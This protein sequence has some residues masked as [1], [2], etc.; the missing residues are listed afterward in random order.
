[1]S[2]ILLIRLSDEK[3]QKKKIEQNNI[4]FSLNEEEKTADIVGIN[5]KIIDLIIPKSIKYESK[6]Y[7]ITSILNG[8]F[9]GS[10]IKSLNFTPDSR[11][12]TIETDAFCRTSI[13]SLTI[14]SQVAELKE[15][16]CN[17]TSKLTNINV[18]PNN[19]YFKTYENHLIIG[20]NKIEITNFD[21]LVFCVRNIK[22]I[23]IPNFIRHICPYAFNGC[24][25]ITIEFSKDLK[26]QIIDSNA[27]RNT[28]L[29]TISIPSQVIEIK[30]FAFFCCHQLQRIEF[31][32]DSKLQKIETDAFSNS[33]IER[34]TIPSQVIQIGIRA[35]SYCL[36]LRWVDFSIDSKLQIIDD[37]AF[38]ESSIFCIS[39]PPQVKRIGV[40]AFAHCDDLQ[41]VEISDNSKLKIFDRC[42]FDHFTIIMIP[43]HLKNIII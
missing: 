6:E 16:W 13:E 2:Q 31:Q 25:L 26:L 27:F 4:I 10:N 40:D 14:P 9:I 19:Q 21:C 42:S 8:A 17:R 39:I 33:I 32:N 3:Q 24:E 41:I 12:Q 5:E 36:L 7:F 30:K 43:T 22:T 11:L 28:S 38:F 20:K 29:T 35:F 15:G 34:I 18:S 1:M 37:F 23:T